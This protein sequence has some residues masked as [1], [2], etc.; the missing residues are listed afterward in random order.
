MN[1]RLKYFLVPAVDC[2]S[3]LLPY[4]HHEN[5]SHYNEKLQLVIIRQFTHINAFIIILY[6]IVN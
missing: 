5:V 2:G 4:D 1:K 3:V 6:I